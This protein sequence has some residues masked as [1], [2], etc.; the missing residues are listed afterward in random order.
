MSAHS[1]RKW[2]ELNWLRKGNKE[3]PLPNLVYCNLTDW[4]GVYY[5]RQKNECCIAN[6]YYDL[7]TR[8]LICVNEN[9]VDEDGDFEE[10]LAHEWRH[11]LQRQRYKFAGATFNMEGDYKENIISY[12]H[13]NWHELD[14]FMFSFRKIETRAT[15]IWFEWLREAGVI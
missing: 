4:S 9:N 13:N 14:A 3:V 7:T 1:A 10:V 11:H 8:A 15:V 6:S 5:P 2:T 12:F